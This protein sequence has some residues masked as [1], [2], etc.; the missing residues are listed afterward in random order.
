MDSAIK[1][2]ESRFGKLKRNGL[3]FTYLGVEHVRHSADH[4]AL[5][6]NNYLHKLK[7]IPIDNPNRTSD[8]TPLTDVQTKQFRSLLCSLLW[9]CLTRLDLIAPVTQLQTEMIAPVFAQIKDVNSLLRKA[10]RDQTQ[11]GLH[12]HR[13]NFPLRILGVSDAGHA[14]KRTV[15][16][17]EGKFVFLTHD[18]TPHASKSEW[19]QDI[20]LLQGYAHPLFF[21]GKKA[22]RVSHSTSH[23]ESL[24]CVS[25]TQTAQLT[26]Q[27]L[28][29]VFSS[30]LL[31]KPKPTTHDMIAMQE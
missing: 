27:R 2:L 13:L 4:I 31:N 16:A 17:Q 24:S 8:T 30:L 6:Q 22:T 5:Y 3:P 28:S 26:A 9:L 10:I 15:Y 7:P 12:F 20:T 19:T 1:K 25:T 23:S 14:T 29:E 11:N 21:S 18:P